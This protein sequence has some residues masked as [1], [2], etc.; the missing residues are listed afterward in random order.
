VA[1]SAARAVGGAPAV[2]SAHPFCKQLL[3]LP[4]V[5]ERVPVSRARLYQMVAAGK[6][7][8]QVK[9]GTR[10]LWIESEVDQWVDELAAKRET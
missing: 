10:S 3:S 1:H 8:R 4:R 6:F 7:P 2:D 5:L 9:I